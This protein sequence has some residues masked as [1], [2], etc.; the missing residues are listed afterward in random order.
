[1]CRDCLLTNTKAMGVRRRLSP[2][3]GAILALASAAPPAFAQ[4]GFPTL[5]TPSG[6]HIALALSRVM[7]SMLYDVSATDPLTYAAVTGVLLVVAA[8]ASYLPARRATRVDPMVALQS[9]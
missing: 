2:L 5:L 7:T 9:E 6:N 1:M 4:G 3:A 8:A